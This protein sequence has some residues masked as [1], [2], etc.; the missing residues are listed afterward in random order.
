MTLTLVAICQAGLF[1]PGLVPGLR[2]LS[3][4][5]DAL[6]YL[7]SWF[8]VL[9]WLHIGECHLAQELCWRHLAG[10][11]PRPGLQLKYISLCVEFRV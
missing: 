8:M 11:R 2:E 6:E 5:V 3:L 4:W 7:C 1:Q 9:L 10:S